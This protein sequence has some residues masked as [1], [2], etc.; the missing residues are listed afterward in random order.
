VSRGG[1]PAAARATIIPIVRQTTYGGLGNGGRRPRSRIVEC[2]VRTCCVVG[3]G[4]HAITTPAGRLAS[5]QTCTVSHTPPGRATNGGLRPVTLSTGPGEGAQAA[6]GPGPVP[7][8]TDPVPARRR[9]PPGRGNQAQETENRKTTGQPSIVGP[10]PTTGP[11]TGPRP[12]AD[13]GSDQTV[14]GRGGHRLGTDDGPSRPVTGTKTPIAPGQRPGAAVARGGVEPPTFRFSV[15][16]SYQLS[17]LA[18]TE[19]TIMF[20]RG[21][22]DGT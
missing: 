11:R 14:P 5:S 1:A 16:R 19:E 12:G 15:G 21:D 2:P 6:P 3:H 17:Y 10:G 9:S 7:I 13:T 4:T 20:F 8:S 18:V 22:P